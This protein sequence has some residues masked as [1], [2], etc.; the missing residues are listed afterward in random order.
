MEE[1]NTKVPV[2]LPKGSYVTLPKDQ[3]EE[4][5]GV[6]KEKDQRIKICIMK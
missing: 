5:E 4:Y 6:L 2:N 1:N 3:I